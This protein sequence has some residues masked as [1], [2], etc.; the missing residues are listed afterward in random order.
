[1]EILDHEM[2][3]IH[4]PELQAIPFSAIREVR[5]QK[6]SVVSLFL[7]ESDFFKDQRIITLIVITKTT[8]Y[9]KDN[10]G[11]RLPIGNTCILFLQERKKRI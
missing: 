7:H 5:G 1:M 2:H 9:A 6:S 10:P 3:Q 8:A 4:E 11:S